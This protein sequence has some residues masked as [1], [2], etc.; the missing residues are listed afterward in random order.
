M[1]PLDNVNCHIILLR[2]YKDYNVDSHTKGHSDEPVSLVP[3]VSQKK[4][5]RDLPQTLQTFQH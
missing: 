3:S 2:H 1:I 5:E 4:T